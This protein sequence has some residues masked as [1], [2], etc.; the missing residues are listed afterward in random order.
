VVLFVDFN[1]K[2]EIFFMIDATVDALNRFNYELFSHDYEA[3]EKKLEIDKFARFIISK[4]EKSG[5]CCR[6]LYYHFSEHFLAF[7]IQKGLG[8]LV[9]KHLGESAN[10]DTII[11]HLSPHWTASN[12]Q[13]WDQ[14]RGGALTLLDQVIDR[15][16]PAEQFGYCLHVSIKISTLLEKVLNNSR[17]D[18]LRQLIPAIPGVENS[19]IGD[20]PA[21]SHAVEHSSPESHCVELLLQ[22]GADPSLCDRDSEDNALFLAV[23]GRNLGFAR[24][25]LSSPTGLKAC[26]QLNAEYFTPLSFAVFRNVTGVAALIESNLRR[27]LSSE[28]SYALEFSKYTTSL[29]LIGHAFE[30]KDV[31]E[32]PAHA[33]TPAIFFPLEGAFAEY[34]ASTMVDSIRFSQ[35][36]L[37]D[38]IYDKQ[39]ASLIINCLNN[40]L[41]RRSEGKIIDSIHRGEPCVFSFGHEGHFSNLLFFDNLMIRLDRGETVLNSVQIFYFEKKQFDLRCLKLLTTDNSNSA[42][43]DC[44]FFDI[45]KKLQAFKTSRCIQLEEALCSVVPA[46]Q[47]GNCTWGNSEALIFIL[48]QIQI[49]NNVVRSEVE[50]DAYAKLLPEL[51]IKH[52][53][54]RLVSKIFTL[55]EHLQLLKDFTI[56][57]GDKEL[58]KSCFSILDKEVKRFPGMQ[59]LRDEVS[60][61]YWEVFPKRKGPPIHGTQS[62]AHVDKK[63]R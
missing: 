3:E 39:V 63:K 60:S 35:R 13:V 29:K 37:S 30:K 6:R 1:E 21:L 57:K 52:E 31:V 5:V 40:F 4:P 9:K 19:Y 56:I 32:I 48:S 22:A 46:L 38:Q 8:Y 33:S 49:I 18:L 27:V 43:N 58:I 62:A 24:L 26:L 23:E 61:L 25:I 2:K 7:F 12:I 15:T 51:L 11:Q 45:I 36:Y 10:S 47:V 54:F 50:Y 14:H 28:V 41:Q 55:L 17:A 53:Q 42:E 16:A 59:D 20:S 44:R 34:I